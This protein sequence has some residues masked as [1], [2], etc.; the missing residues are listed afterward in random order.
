MSLSLNDRIEII[1]KNP[2]FR[3]LP[4]HELT[5]LA[6]LF[7]EQTVTPN[8][9]VVNEGDPVDSIYLIVSG[10]AEVSRRVTELDEEQIYNV[11]TL[12]EGD[13]IGLSQESFFSQS[14]LRTGTVISA[15]PTTLLVITLKDLYHFLQSSK[16]I[17]LTLKE[18]CENILL[19]NFI[20]KS[21]LFS[22]LDIAQIQEL[23]K[24][25]TKLNLALGDILFK[26]NDIADKFY[27]VIAGTIAIT[28]NRKR[29]TKLGPS[30]IVGEGAFLSGVK[31][32][33]TAV[34]ESNSELFVLDASQIKH[35]IAIH[36]QT[37]HAPYQIDQ[38]KPIPRKATVLLEK[39]TQEKEPIQVLLNPITDTKLVLSKQDYLIWKNLDGQTSL[40]SIKEN[41]SAILKD[42]TVQAIYLRILEM[43]N[44]GFV[45]I[46]KKTFFD[47][48]KEKIQLAW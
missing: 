46:K 1:S 28:R 12:R 4:S 24:T 2:L 35:I 39:L 15:L 11:A 43:V 44:A 5:S 41:N 16:Y 22:H 42:M 14:G 23:I 38:L 27:F 34:A 31:H 6:N 45:D 7:K 20:K 40:L 26:E 3:N 33:A 36:L 47:T 37:K 30:Q 21:H 18:A 10:A 29:V 25:K 9:L 8:T 17:P 19:V 32:N 13:T 48:L